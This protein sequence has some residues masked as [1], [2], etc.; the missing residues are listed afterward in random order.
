MKVPKTFILFSIWVIM[1]HSIHKES[2]IF[3]LLA[4]RLKIP[5]IVRSFAMTYID[6]TSNRNQPPRVYIS[7]PRRAPSYKRI[8]RTQTQACENGPTHKPAH[9]YTIHAC[10]V[11]HTHLWTRNVSRLHAYACEEG[12]KRAYTIRIKASDMA[13]GKVIKCNHVITHQI[14]NLYERF[15][16]N[17]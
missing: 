7:S 15:G 16:A 1:L 9:R 13:T 11:Q 10:T 8:E 5:Q 4:A 3:S 2:K 17:A 6:E 14:L 12:R